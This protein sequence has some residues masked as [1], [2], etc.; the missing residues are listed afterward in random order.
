MVQPSLEFFVLVFAMFK[1][2][3]VPVVVDPGMGYERMVQCHNQSK[4]EAFIGVPMAHVL[5][6]FKYSKYFKNVKSL[7]TVGRRWLWGGFTMRQL[8]QISWE[9]YTPVQTR[10]DETAAILFTT[11]STGPAKGVVYTH[12]IFDSQVRHIQE[13][14]GI[15]PDEVDLPTFPLFSLFDPALGMTAVIPDMDPRFPAKADPEKI[16]EA[17]VD[18]GVTNMFASPA[19]LQRVGEY[20]IE[21]EIK[22]PS[23][24][25]VISA[26]APVSP[27]NIEKFSFMLTGD[28]EIFTPYGAT[29]AMPVLSIGSREILNETRKFSEKGYGMCVG[30]PLEGIDVR[31]IKISDE[32]IEGWSDK[33]SVGDGEIG[34]I[35][36]KGDIITRE[37][38]EEP[39][40]NALSKI[41][42]GQDIWHRMGDLGWRD[43]KGRIWFCGRKSHR[44]ITENGSL[45]TIPCEAIFNRHPSVARSALVGIGKAPRQKPV[46]CIELKNE[47][48]GVDKDAL[49]HEL[50]NIAA[51]N[52]MTEDIKTL[53][54]HDKFPVDVRHNAKISRE[55]LAKWADS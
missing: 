26:G 4:A 40:H 16:I 47:G 32:S 15:G 39:H 52:H 27:V 29:E 37:Y 22:L 8:Q 9:P 17:I 13:H 48:R 5:R 24:K 42:D 19:L 51:K 7:V 11:G 18:Q 54:F 53:L 35:T 50:L 36:V 1:V 45:F 20:G 3:A 2:G 44:V 21:E 30:R 23:L 10:A 14:F 33:L 34:E 46:I 55:E 49:K 28:A 31:I 43:N 41:R 12:G 38:F 25:R 6:R